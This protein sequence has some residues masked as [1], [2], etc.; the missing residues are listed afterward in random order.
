MGLLGES[1]DDPQS[2][3]IM[4]LAGGLLSGNMGAGVTG[5]G[6]ALA[7]AKDQAMKRRMLELQMEE[8]RARQAEAQ[9]AEQERERSRMQ[10]GANEAAVRAQLLGGGEFDPREFM[11]SNPGANTAG[12]KDAMDLNSSMNPRPTYRELAPGGTMMSIGKDGPRVAF[13]APDR[14]VVPS[15]PSAIQEYQYAKQ[16]GYQG[17]FDEWKKSNARAGATSVSMPKIDIKMG[18]SIANQVGPM[19]KDSKDKAMSGLKLVDSA[20]RILDA[21]DKGNLYAGPL[22]NIQLKAAQYGDKFGITGKDTATK[23][24]NTRAVIRGMAEQAVAARSQLGSQ[25][26][27]SNAE[28]EL[29]TKAT[30]GDIGELTHGEVAQIA[31]L[32]DR[33]G[34]QL[35]GQHDEQIANVSGDPNTANLAKFY[36]VPPL[37]GARKQQIGGIKFLGFE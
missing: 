36:K 20:N 8:R 7:G 27:I 25:A 24:Q 26:Q 33:L 13:T 4:A 22:A 1:W 3:A 35:Y 17:T 12:L 9:R 30:A 16:Q 23:I 19:L 32:N 14:P 15:V 10:G 18:E 2:A 5:Y 28:Q 31:K 34:R 6:A 11:R 29:L 21:A 37:P